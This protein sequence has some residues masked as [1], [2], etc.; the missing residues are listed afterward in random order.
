MMWFWCFCMVC[1]HLI[2]NINFSDLPYNF[3][4][5]VFSEHKFISSLR[6]FNFRSRRFWSDH[7]RGKPFALIN[8]YLL[9]WL[10]KE[11]S[12]K[13][14]F[15]AKLKLGYLSCQDEQSFISRHRSR[16]V[17]NWLYHLMKKTV[18][19]SKKYRSFLPH[20]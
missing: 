20:F 15:L 13:T 3:G 6:V 12:F 16:V 8:S 19:S 5:F 2:L 1:L 9:F 4:L 10:K 7:L 11:L 18:L 17:P 14:F